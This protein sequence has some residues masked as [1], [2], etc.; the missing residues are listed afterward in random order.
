[1]GMLKGVEVLSRITTN[2]TDETTNGTTPML[3]DSVRLR[4]RRI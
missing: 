2:G 1:M 4:Y 3:G